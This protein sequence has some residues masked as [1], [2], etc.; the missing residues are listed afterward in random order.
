VATEQVKVKGGKNH[1]LIIRKTARGTIISEA[2]ADFADM[3]V[4]TKRFQ[5]SKRPE[6]GSVLKLA[7]SSN[8]LFTESHTVDGLIALNSASNF[9]EFS[10]A[11]AHIDNTSLS[12][13]YA[14]ADGDIGYY[15]TGAIPV[16]PKANTGLMPYPAWKREFWWTGQ[17]IPHEAMPHVLNPEEGYVVT[18]NNRVVDP[19][20]YPHYL[21]RLGFIGY[22]AKSL[23][24][25]IK[26][27][28]ASDTPVTVQDM[29]DWQF[30]ITNEYARALIK[31]L[32]THF[33]ANTLDEEAGLDSK[34]KEMLL[35]MY[36]WE[37]PTPDHDGCQ[38]AVDS[39]ATSIY[40]VFA[41][42]VL[43]LILERGFEKGYVEQ[44]LKHLG[45]SEEARK[46]R[47]EKQVLHMKGIGHDEA[48]KHSSSMEGLH[49]AGAVLRLLAE[50][51][52]WW[53]SHFEGGPKGAIALALQSTW[54]SCAT[55]LFKSEDM[56]TWEWGKVHQLELQH[57]MSL[58]FGPEPFNRGPYPVPG[59]NFTPYIMTGGHVTFP[60]TEKAI[61]A[62]VS[63]S[64]RS[65]HNMTGNHDSDTF[66]ESEMIMPGG[67]S[68]HLSSAHYN[69]QTQD[70]LDGKYVS[71]HTTMAT[72]KRIRHLLPGEE[73][74]KLKTG[75]G[76]CT[77]L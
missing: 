58:V 4:S 30:C 49:A 42:D 33:P 73:L 19:A 70:W 3:P 68:G 41:E 35:A 69:D 47:H 40:E 48:L 15:M 25:L 60:R 71:M 54:E 67:N 20:Q 74:A 18:S 26:K 51:E 27:K 72:T 62:N 64:M 56:K 7:L 34:L 61:L 6:D 43:Q 53:I 45:D 65:V 5:D 52:S 10:E 32:Q 36:E 17:N 66:V 63:A 39:Y 46:K 29:K 24:D 2:V 77:I 9:K 8:I 31:V 44:E 37:K 1:N 28:L 14:N 23:D 13:V 59:D 11:C 12:I 76:G 22:R 50:P 21:G 16:R 57:P 75:N 55:L 38:V